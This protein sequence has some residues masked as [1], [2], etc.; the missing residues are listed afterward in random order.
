MAHYTKNNQIQNAV[1]LLTQL[2]KFNEAQELSKKHANKKGADGA[3]LLD[4]SILLK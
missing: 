1:M 3:S 2:K 4:P